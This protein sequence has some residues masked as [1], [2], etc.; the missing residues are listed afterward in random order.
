MQEDT[1]L[2][3]DPSASSRTVVPWSVVPMCAGAMFLAGCGSGGLGE[4]ESTSGY[5]SDE[6]F[7]I[8]FR[9][10][11]EAEAVR[12][13]AAKLFEQRILWF[14][15][16]G[17]IVLGS[18]LDHVRIDSAFHAAYFAIADSRVES[19]PR[20]FSIAAPKQ[21]VRAM[22]FSTSQSSIRG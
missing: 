3:F 1:F 21:W 9:A 2:A 10:F 11:H 4:P 7:L 17:S 15:Q 19:A 6:G 13:P 5:L 12:I 8:L 16:G 22:S 18:Q 20:S 14:E